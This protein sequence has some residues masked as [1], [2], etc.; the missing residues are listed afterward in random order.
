ML[1]RKDQRERQEFLILLKLRERQIG[2]IITPQASDRVQA[3]AMLNT[4]HILRVMDGL[5]QP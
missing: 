2:D 1:G 4:S 3:L 5:W